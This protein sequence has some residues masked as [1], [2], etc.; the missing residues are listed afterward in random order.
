MSASWYMVFFTGRLFS[1]F[2]FFFYKSIIGT[3]RLLFLTRIWWGVLKPVLQGETCSWNR[4]PQSTMRF[5]FRHEH[6]GHFYYK[7][8]QFYNTQ[9]CESKNIINVQVF[10]NCCLRRSFNISRP[11]ITAN[12]NLGDWARLAPTSTLITKR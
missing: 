2:F 1:C 3:K 9:P 6:S 10:V 5:R 8:Y 11:R 4:Y 7:H 12:K